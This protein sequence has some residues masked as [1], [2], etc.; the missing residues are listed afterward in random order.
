MEYEIWASVSEL[1]SYDITV[2]F[3]VCWQLG[4]VLSWFSYERG[5]LA[6][7]EMVGV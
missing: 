3:L 2:E 4:R 7:R 5:G 1:S 6:V